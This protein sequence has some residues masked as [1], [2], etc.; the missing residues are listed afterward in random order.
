MAYAPIALSALSAA[1][2]YSYH[3]HSLQHAVTEFKSQQLLTVDRQKVHSLPPIGSLHKTGDGYIHTHNSFIDQRDRI[4]RLLGCPGQDDRDSIAAAVSH[5]RALDLEQAA[6]DAG[7]AAT[8]L[9]SYEQWDVLPQAEPVTDTPIIIRK[10][11]SGIPALPPSL[12]VGADK[13]LRGR[14]PRVVE[15]TR[16]VA[17]PAAGNRLASHGADVLWVTSPAYRAYHS[18]DRDVGRCKR[19]ITLDVN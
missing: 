5:W 6:V 13:C 17:G 2:I 11:A 1:L 4:E 15:I 16:V 8:P 7:L 3:D 12:K 10:I 19:T 14:G 18:L 9:R